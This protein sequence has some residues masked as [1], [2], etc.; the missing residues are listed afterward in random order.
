MKNVQ[1]IDNAAN[2]T[3]SIFQATDDEFA[4]LFPD[5]RDMEM[6]DDVVERLGEDVAS[7][8]LG[9]LWRR[10]ILKRDAQGIHGTL[11]YGFDQIREFLPATL[12]EVDWDNRFIN[13]AQRELF[14]AKR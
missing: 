13:A 5:G 11:F 8:V 4:L 12:R 3:F 2:A 7:S 14:A 6:A 1:I 9:P 10:P